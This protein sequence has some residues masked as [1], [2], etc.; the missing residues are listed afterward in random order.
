MMRQISIVLILLLSAFSPYAD[1]QE[2]GEPT[3]PKSQTAY[4]LIDIQMFYFQG[5]Q[6]PL[7]NPEGASKKAKELLEVFRSREMPV[8]H[9]RHQVSKNGDIHPLVEPGQG[10]K[11]FTKTQANA[12]AGTRLLEHLK[13]QQITH[14]VIAGM[15][16]HMCV[17]AAARAAHDLGFSVTVAADACAT[18]DL[19]YK[20]NTVSALDVHTSTLASIKGNYGQVMPVKQLI[21]HISSAN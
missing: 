5:G 18:R 19:V 7:V 11:V 17:E 8:I 1:G 13:Q 15:M 3:F 2:A 12:F 21:S 14:L 10:E 9:V 16:T 20:N 6:M 4:L